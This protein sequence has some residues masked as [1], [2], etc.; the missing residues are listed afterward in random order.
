[1]QREHLSLNLICLLRTYIVNLLT[2][3]T[4]E[5]EK[6]LTENERSLCRVSQLQLLDLIGKTYEPYIC[7]SHFGILYGIKFGA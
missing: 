1:M 4:V 7:L 3:V 2:N 6:L 5:S